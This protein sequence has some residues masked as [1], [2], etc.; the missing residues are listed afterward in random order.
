MY[1]A[2]RAAEADTNGISEIERERIRRIALN[3]ERLNQCKVLEAAGDLAFKTAPRY[4]FC[5]EITAAAVVNLYEL[6]KGLNVCPFQ[7]MKDRGFLFTVS[8]RI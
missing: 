2:S 8:E 6:R 5:L 4:I 3:K 7:G 1:T